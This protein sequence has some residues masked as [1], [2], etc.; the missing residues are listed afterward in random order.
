MV[1]VIQMVPSGNMY[2][3]GTYWFKLFKGYHVVQ[4]I[5]RV[6]SCPRKANG[7]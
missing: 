4:G 1:K 6:P 2:T 5:N 3:K 7:A